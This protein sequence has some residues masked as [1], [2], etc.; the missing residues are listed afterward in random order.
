MMWS[1]HE[2]GA[3]GGRIGPPSLASMD[4]YQYALDKA[5]DAD[6]WIIINAFQSQTVVQLVTRMEATAYE[7]YV[8]KG[9]ESEYDVD[10]IRRYAG[11][12]NP[13]LLN[14]LAWW[15]TAKPA[16]IVAISRGYGMIRWYVQEDSKIIDAVTIGGAVSGFTDI[17]TGIFYDYWMMSEE[18]YAAQAYA[19]KNKVLIGQLIAE[20][21]L[22][23]GTILAIIVL[24]LL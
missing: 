21:V 24:L 12:G 19:T 2:A 7:T 14:T 3:G 9:K 16:A 13:F 18:V 15:S 1:M 20:D 8:A 6:A 11:S 17:A 22:K 4:L 23:Y 5:L 10:K